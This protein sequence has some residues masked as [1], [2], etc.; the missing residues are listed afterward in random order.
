MAELRIHDQ[1]SAYFKSLRSKGTNVNVD[2]NLP[3]VSGKILTEHELL[4]ILNKESKLNTEAILKPD[5]TKTPIDSEGFA[6]PIPI[7]PYVTTEIFLGKHELTEWI[8]SDN[9]NFEPITDGSSDIV[10]KDSWYPNLTQPREVVYVKYR[11]R[12]GNIVSPWSDTIKFKAM[13]KGIITPELSVVEDALEPTLKTTPL[14]SYGTFNNLEHVSSTWRIVE[15][16]SGAVAHEE[17]NSVTNKVSYRV[18]ADVLD[19]KKK[20]KVYVKHNTNAAEPA[21]QSSKWSIGHYLTPDSKISRPTLRYDGQNSTGPIVIGSAFQGEGSHIASEWMIYNGT[22]AKIAEF[23]YDSINL[24]SLP[25]SK[26][27]TQGHNYII[28]VRYI[29]NE[30]KSPLGKVEVNIPN[31]GGS[32]G[33]GNEKGMTINATTSDRGLGISVVPFVSPIREDIQYFR[34]Q[35]RFDITD[36]LT[37]TRHVKITNGLY[38]D[39]N[40]EDSWNKEL[41]Y[42][43]SPDEGYKIW[44]ANMDITDPSI[45][46]S[47]NAIRMGLTKEE[48]YKASVLTKKFDYVLG[49]MTLENN[50]T[51]SPLARFTDPTGVD[52]GICGYV[53]TIYTLYKKVGQDWQLV[54]EEEDTRKDFHRF[55]NLD[56]DTD[57]K[58]RAKHK[59]NVFNY[60]KDYLFRSASY[61]MA[62]PVVKLEGSALNWKIKASGY[63]LTNYTG[64][65]PEHDSTTYTL[66]NA[67]TGQKLWEVIKDRTHKTEINIPSSVVQ[68]GGRYKVYVK[69]HSGGDVESRAKEV[70][71]Y[72]KP[73]RIEYNSITSNILTGQTKF[74]PKGTTFLINGYVA[75]DIETGSPVSTEV[76]AR[77]DWVLEAQRG[78][79]RV[80]VEEKIGKTTE[81]NSWTPDAK[82]LETDETIY[83]SAICYSLNGLVSDRKTVTFTRFEKYMET[84]DDLWSLKIGDWERGGVFGIVPDKCVELNELI[85]MGEWGEASNM[86]VIEKDDPINPEPRKYV[87][88][89]NMLATYKGKLYRPIVEQLWAQFEPSAT[90]GER[91]EEVT[92]YIKLPGIVNIMELTGIEP[93]PKLVRKGETLPTVP[94]KFANKVWY[95]TSSNSIPF[96]TKYGVGGNEFTNQWVKIVSPNTKKMCFISSLPMLENFSVNDIIARQPEYNEIDQF[97]IRFG[98][99]LYYIRLATKEEVQLLLKVDTTRQNIINKLSNIN[100]HNYIPYVQRIDKNASGYK[101]LRYQNERFVEININPMLRSGYI[102]FT[103]TPISEEEAPYQD[104][105]IRKRY[106]NFHGM[107][108]KYGQSGTYENGKVI[109]FNT[110]NQTKGESTN[111]FDSGLS[112]MYDR[113]TDTGYFGRIHKDKLISYKEL[114]R[115]Y[116]VDVSSSDK[117]ADGSGS[118]NNDAQWYDVFYWHGTIGLMP[119]AAPWNKMY[120]SMLRKNGL[121]YGC[122]M[123]P[124]HNYVG[125]IEVTDKNNNKKLRLAISAPVFFYKTELIRYTG[126]D[127]V[128]RMNNY[129]HFKSNMLHG[130]GADLLLKTANITAP[131]IRPEDIHGSSRAT[132]YIRG[133]SFTKTLTFKGITSDL[134]LSNIN[135]PNSNSFTT[136]AGKTIM[137]SKVAQSDYIIIPIGYGI[138]NED[139]ETYGEGNIQYD[140]NDTMAYLTSFFRPWLKIIPDGFDGYLA[141][142][143]DPEYI[144]PAMPISYTGEGEN[145]QPGTRL[146]FYLNSNKTGYDLKTVKNVVVKAKGPRRVL[147]QTPRD[148]Q[149]NYI[150]ALAPNFLDGYRIENEDKVIFQDSYSS[151]N[152][153]IRYIQGPDMGTRTTVE[154]SATLV[155]NKN[156]AW[157][158]IESPFKHTATFVVPVSTVEG[159]E[160]GAS[161]FKNRPGK[162]DLWISYYPH[163]LPWEDITNVTYILRD[164]S[165]SYTAEIADSEMPPEYGRFSKIFLHRK[166]VVIKDDATGIALTGN[167]NSNKLTI[168][169]VIHLKAGGTVNGPELEI[170]IGK[171]DV[172]ATIS[173]SIGLRA[174]T[175]V[176]NFGHYLGMVNYNNNRNDVEDVNC[177]GG[178]GKTFVAIQHVDIRSSQHNV[179]PDTITND[180]YKHYGMAY[181]NAGGIT[182]SQGT[183]HTTSSSDGGHIGYSTTRTYNPIRGYARNGIIG[184]GSNVSNASSPDLTNWY[185]HTNGH[186]LVRIPGKS[187]TSLGSREYVR[188][189][190]IKRDQYRP[191]IMDQFLKLVPHNEQN[192][193]MYQGDSE[194]KVSFSLIVKD[195]RSDPKK[196]FEKIRLL[197]IK[198]RDFDRIFGQQIGSENN[199]FETYININ[200]SSTTFTENMARFKFKIDQELN[201]ERDIINAAVYVH[202][203]LKQGNN[204][205]ITI[206]RNLKDTY[207][208]IVYENES[209]AGTNITR[210]GFASWGWANGSYGSDYQNEIAR[211]M[212]NFNNWDGK[213][214]NVTQSK[215]N[216]DGGYNQFSYTLKPE[217]PDVRVYF[218]NT[219]IPPGVLQQW[220]LPRDQSLFTGPF[221]ASKGRGDYTYVSLRWA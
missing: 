125:D 121:L 17:I 106:P 70:D 177:F 193:T 68:L 216:Q 157:N 148:R 98:T 8:A 220:A 108:L 170:P 198:R 95:N 196:G 44:F 46:I 164:G 109:C 197:S 63:S 218:D 142:D 79:E 115:A 55:N 147:D 65:N 215:T 124:F 144:W 139:A 167:K 133:K 188:T 5:I 42:S 128:H 107:G 16:E 7:A 184:Y 127:G 137:N 130:M 119:N 160:I 92:K 43:W 105:M 123:G 210:F 33:S 40:V 111:W 187:L 165:R 49:N 22:G 211:I 141:P 156:R 221:K 29:T 60:S 71:F 178:D 175:E 25:V 47:G 78:S 194:D 180:N 30:A 159:G 18:P 116:N 206:E 57:Y 69:F 110:K 199:V 87:W 31:A 129:L 101:A 162:V 190:S 89:R 140:E 200:K 77:T 39:Q 203:T 161:V 26:F 122:N 131:L 56:N 166:R 91:W 201:A 113:Y 209:K 83:V 103:I 146:L 191:F 169:S 202:P 19:P 104:S 86:R 118:S 112:L 173:T 214:I 35:I 117:V 176:E 13:D 149:A 45:F 14:R 186:V 207:F 24:T 58:I 208:Y 150:E 163:E 181:S 51:L 168:S 219:L 96:F 73:Y 59:T 174:S 76:L 90:L 2:L 12:S 195:I 67:S 205:V 99:R 82:L 145:V 27:I 75:K 88:N 37:S 81:P 72:I 28:T 102:F 6:G 135:I 185:E 132:E 189:A 192:N 204:D 54:R 10:F 183:R 38:N 134:K 213:Y 94:D 1:S 21:W 61:I 97:T 114:M 93:D 179:V 9:E 151:G 20:Y 120:I 15:L 172:T 74:V 154:I 52:V 171:L 32:G 212:N 158:D 80:K 84:C 85:Y 136:L 23:P 62:D 153:Y 217:Y 4:E 155:L 50:D 64:P 100:T 182:V 11:F 66:T 126:K 143:P 152:N 41:S 53:K 36:G 48:R 34:Y 3:D 138:H